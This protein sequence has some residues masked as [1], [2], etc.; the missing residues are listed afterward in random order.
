MVR[1]HIRLNAALTVDRAGWDSWWE[2]LM[3]KF[4]PAR[5]Y[6][7]GQYGTAEAPDG[8]AFDQITDTTGL[9]AAEGL[10][11]MLTSQL[12]P[13]GQ[14]WISYTP[15]P[16]FDQDEE[17]V[18]YYRN[19]S[20]SI[21][22][23]VL[24]SNFYT[25]RN[26]ANLELAALGSTALFVRPG[27]H[28][29]FQFQHIDLGTFNFTEDE[30]GRPQEIYSTITLTPAQAAEK[31]PKLGP[32]VTAELAKP[33][34]KHTSFHK[35]LHYVGPNPDHNPDKL[36][37]KYKKFVSLWICLTDEIEL[38]R[39][40]FDSFPYQI[41]RLAKWSSLDKWG[42]APGR[43]AMPA[44]HQLNWLEHL[45]DLAA[46]LQVRPR[47][48]T[49]ADQVGQVNLRAGGRTIVSAEAAAAQLP[50]EW[51]TSSRYD[52]GKD[53]A[54][55]KREAVKRMFHQPLWQFL[56]QIDRTMTA[57]EVNARERE[58]LTLFA[59]QLSRH[60]S[61]SQALHHRLFD[62]A[63]QKGIIGAPPAKLTRQ[64]GP[65]IPNPVART[66]SRLAR[67][68]RDQQTDSYEAFLE[69]I[70]R[71]A[72]LD[73]TVLDQFDLAAGL[74]ELG[75]NQNLPR[76]LIREKR[77]VIQIREQR[78]QQEAA[79]QA[80]EAAP[81]VAQAAATASQIDP[82]ALQNIAGQAGLPA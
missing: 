59:P 17:I 60:E 70:T 4:L 80:A 44:L 54:N 11:A 38:D 69:T 32:K 30:D 57:Y 77:D 56:A 5:A 25:E 48:V 62:I 9:E 79:M 31:F 46:E 49:L 41:S 71:T 7:R 37:S 64:T 42:L 14:D 34:S 23:H 10:G 36:E 78:A 68:S 26:E 33:D 15:P 3:A 73:P 63:L 21:L 40:G 61:D 53:R 1:D 65:D 28:S 67:L 24:H 66:E 72:Q 51:L 81:K 6:R 20:R 47:T 19:A 13:A 76:P 75:K 27:K 45:E 29:L 18:D 35:F 8:T 74:V 82:A 2:A 12:T 58:Q 55:D 50:K 43:K 16:P 52:I 22:N 39:G